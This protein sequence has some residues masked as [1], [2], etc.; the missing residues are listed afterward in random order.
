MPERVPENVYRGE[1]IAYPGPWAFDIGRAHI[2]LVSDQELEALSNPD[3]VLNLALTFDKNEAS[4]RQ[5]CERAQAAGQRTLVI[6]FD[7]FFKQYRPGQD[8]PRRLTPDMD[9]YIQR[10]A[11]ISKFAEGYGLGLELSLLSPLEI[12]P[13]YAAKTGESGL[14]MHYRKSLRDPVTGAFSVQLWR[15]R[16]WVNNKGP[17][18]V[19]DAGVRVFAFRERA[20]GGTPYRVVDQ[21]Q[22]VEVKE[23]IEVEEWTNVTAGGGV[24][25]EVRGKGGPSE[26]GLNRVLVVQQYKTPEMDYFSPKALPYVNELI[27]RYAAA[28][29]KL[30]GLYSDEMHIQQDWGYFSHHDNGELAMRYVSPGLAARYAEL[31]GEEYRDFAKWLVYFTY[32]QEDFAHDLSAKQGVSHVLGASPQDIRR[33]ALLRSRYYRLLQDGVVD[34]FVAA[35]RHAEE[36]MGHRLESRAHATWAESPTIDHWSTPGERVQPH[37]YE[38]TSNFVWSNTVHQAASACHDYFKWGDFLTGGGNDHPEGGWLDRDYYALALSCSTGIL[39]EVPLS[40]CA[41]WG[42]PAEISQR[43]QM[44]AV[45][46][47]TTGGPW[48]P[49]Q[50]LQHRDCDVL[51][52]Y[53]LDLVAVE[54]RFGSW[55]TQYGYGNLITQWKLLERGRAVDG[56][57][58]VAGRRFTTLATQFEPFPSEKLL[59]LLKDFAERGGRLIWSGP[60]PVLTA[61]GT[62]A[63][64]PWC[65]LLGVRYVPGANEGLIAP[66]RVVTFE[67][68][69][70]GV[71]PQMI[72]T[73]F[74]VDRIYAVAPLEG[75]ETVARCR[76]CVIGTRRSLPGGGSAA[77]LGYR[78][79]DDQ[80]QSL[81][82]DVRNWFEVLSTLGAYPP[83]GTFA[84]VNDNTEVL[85]RTGE[86]LACRFPNGAVT[87]TRHLRDLV[88]D[89]PGGFARDREADGKYMEAHPLPPDTLD[90]QE[91]KVNGHSVTYHGGQALA[92]R[93]DAEGRLAA[94][95]GAGARSITIDGR[96]TVYADQPMPLVSWAPV[97]EERRVPGGAVMQ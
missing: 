14:W 8:Q 83:S 4:L 21:G 19:E 64:G 68:A 50:G 34:L 48:T 12:G 36:R 72:L 66:G 71:Q 24:R 13:A 95:C 77:F 30:N 87:I 55:T 59:T 6:A 43:R 70:A 53:P 26:G 97:A 74:L 79:R 29:V 25:I 11:A 75:T 90:L 39:N 84:G 7:H 20:V 1:L 60:P 28:G 82:Y 2:I 47:G 67:G 80:A 46:Y 38:Y 52:L 42:M 49:V 73:D 65:E 86:Y 41:H 78:P 44:L 89:W 58:E 16:Q 88:E 40:Y 61:E 45:A 91:Y 22:I 32:G 9:E 15:Q 92:F 81:G 93:V 5:I 69:L 17:I 33:T 63:L 51:M 54:E 85:S 62:D 18:R 23:G 56:A 10:I 37:Q 94:F 27:D 76:D 96:E 57:L 31:Y 3:T 35:K